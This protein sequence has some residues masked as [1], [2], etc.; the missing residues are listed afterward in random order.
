MDENGNV[1]EVEQGQAGTDGVLQ[2]QNGSL[3]YYGISVNDVFAYFLT[4]AK[5]GGITPQPTPFPTTQPELDKIVAF[6]A[7]HRKTFPDPE[8]LAVEVKNSWVEATNLPNLSSYITI[9]ATVPSYDQSNPNLWTVNGQKTV[10]LALTG[11]HVVGSVAGH[12]EMIWATFEH[13]GNTPLAAYAYDST[14]GTKT[15]PAS[16]AGN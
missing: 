10:Q 6:A 9:Q 12:A 11:M 14:S 16:T 3:V 8:A 15:V 1:V 4:G 7:G 2:A 5:D 13:F